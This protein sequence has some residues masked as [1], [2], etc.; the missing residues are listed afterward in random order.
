MGTVRQL[1]AVARPRVFLEV[2]EL[3]AP[4]RPAH[5]RRWPGTTAVVVD[6]RCRRWEITAWMLDT[7]TVTEQNVMR[8]AFGQPL[9]DP[10]GRC[11]PVEPWMVDDEPCYLYVPPALRWTGASALQGGRH[12]RNRRAHGQLDQE[13]EAL[14]AELRLDALRGA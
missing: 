10:A 4:L 8:A 11:A 6:P 9:I 14:T 13:M 12:V 3:E 5:C 2:R 7:L 1:R